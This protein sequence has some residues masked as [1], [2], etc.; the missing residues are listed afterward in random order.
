M[1]LE[2]KIRTKVSRK[3]IIHRSATRENLMELMADKL[4]GKF[5]G[6]RRGILLK[7][8]G[9]VTWLKINSI[10]RFYQYNKFEHICNTLLIKKRSVAMIAELNIVVQY[11]YCS[12]FLIER[13]NLKFE[14]LIL[15]LSALCVLFI[16][17]AFFIYL[18]VLTSIYE[19][20]LHVQN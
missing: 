2:R 7:Y 6:F 3:K 1:T 9:T 12:R 8:R 20:I 4:H 17:H 15:T 11:C 18:H 19:N 16:V 5:S 10:R 13:A 14:I